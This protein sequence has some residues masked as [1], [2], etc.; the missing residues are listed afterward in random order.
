[1]DG[2]LDTGAAASTA[3]HPVLDRALPCSAWQKWPSDSAINCTQ[4]DM[5]DKSSIPL[6]DVGPQR[7]L[8]FDG[9]QLKWFRPVALHLEWLPTPLTRS[10]EFT[11][12]R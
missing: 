4:T 10:V 12:S 2:W 5:Q 6:E 11:T 7:A 1:M 3:G 9:P 8:R